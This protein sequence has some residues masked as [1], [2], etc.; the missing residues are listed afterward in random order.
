MR[1]KFD[2]NKDIKDL[3]LAKMKYDEG[4]RWLYKYEHPVP[5]K[6][7]ESIGGCAYG[8]EAFIPDWLIDTWDP[9]E[10][11]FYPKYFAKRE[12]RKKE[13]V[14]FYKKMYGEPLKPQH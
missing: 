11:A 10:K 5:K 12:R 3:R 1:A 8:R 9:M 7:P 6:F 2:E 14:E 13:Y 4:E